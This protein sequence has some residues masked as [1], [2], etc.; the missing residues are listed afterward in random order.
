MYLPMYLSIYLS[1]SHHLTKN[2]RF[3]NYKESYKYTVTGKSRINT[4]GNE[5]VW[6]S[7]ISYIKIVNIETVEV[8][9]IIRA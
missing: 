8:K 9:T 2:T 4:S 3:K 7:L 6:D 5:N 1:I